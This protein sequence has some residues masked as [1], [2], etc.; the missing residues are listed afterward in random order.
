M[1]APST[2]PVLERI[3]QHPA[4]HAVLRWVAHDADT[5]LR[6]WTDS[7]HEPG[8]QRLLALAE[9]ADLPVVFVT[10]GVANLLAHATTG[11]VFAA[12]RG[13]YSFFVR[14]HAPAPAS[15]RVHDS[16]DGPWDLTPLEP[17]WT[18][19]WLDDDDE[20]RDTLREAFEAASR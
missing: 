1:D 2:D 3:A 13:R 17:T 7:G 11:V 4:N 12:H 10:C 14:G 9:S 19:L 15:A 5:A 8:A 18:G 16:L 6:R 20:D